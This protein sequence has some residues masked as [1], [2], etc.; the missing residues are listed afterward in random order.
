MEVRS[1]HPGVTA[2]QV[3]RQTGFDLAF[4]DPIPTT[5]PPSAEVLRILREQV[6]PHRY[7]IGRGACVPADLASDGTTRQEV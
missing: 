7:V 5:P 4:P 3:R 6:D 2:D 1:L